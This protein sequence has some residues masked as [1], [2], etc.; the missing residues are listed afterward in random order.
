M[1]VTTGGRTRLMLEPDAA[2]LLAGCGIPYV[3]HDVAGSADEAV[4]AAARIGYPVVLKVI[5]EDV[6]HK[7]DAGGVVTG[8]ADEAA[9]RGG[10]ATMLREV[11]ARCPGARIDGALVARHVSGGRELIIGAVRDATF[12][13]TVMAG[14]GGVFAE[15]LADVVFRLPPLQREDGLEMLSELRGARLLAGFRGEP[16]VDLDAVADVIVKVGDLLASHPE[17]AEIDLNPVI[18][19]AGGCVAL[20]ARVIVTSAQGAQSLA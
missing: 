5:S 4:A 13:P 18:A 20:D 19:S 11:S 14:L 1:S 8:L 2:E 17:I 9:V 3:E 12:G 15:A 7:T 6:V 16:P 10:M